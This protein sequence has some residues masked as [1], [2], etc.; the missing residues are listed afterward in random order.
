VKTKLILAL[1][2][3]C[4]IASAQ[5]TWTQKADFGGAARC[6]AVGF[7]IGTK[8]YIGTGYDGSTLYKDF[9][10]WDQATNVWTQKVDFGGIGRDEAI[11]FSIGTKGYIG[12]G[13]Y[14]N[15]SIWTSLKDFWEWNQTTNV[16]T[17][18][19]NFGG[20]ARSGA[21]GF[22]IGT[23]G[24]IGTGLDSTN[25]TQDFWEWNQAT[26][27]WTQKANFGGTI[28]YT[29]VGFSINTM[30]YIGTGLD[31][32]N[33]TQDFWQWNQ[34]TNVWTQKA[35]FSG[36]ARGEATGFCINSKGYIGTGTG[37]H[38][39]GD[40]WEWNQATN[41]WTQKANF[42][43]V[44]RYLAVGF[45]ISSKGYIGLGSDGNNFQDFWEFDPNGNGVNEISNKISVSVFPNPS[46]GMFTIQANSQQ[47]L[48]NN[49]IE[50]YNVL[51]ECIYQHICISANQQIDLSSQP[52][53]VY[54]YQISSNAK[55]LASGKFVKE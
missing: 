55:I 44:A 46:S 7:S 45:S 47:L 12:M 23:K 22:S 28:K 15:G 17:Q 38:P 34:A 30:G 41:V 10:E 19:A 1:L 13:S 29:S 31:S 36:T 54:L 16:W 42:G 21:I 33:A 14:F 37:M 24:Y 4:G 3:I 8:G 35:N 27:I 26:N 39:Y 11:G 9:W 40:F 48:A 49:Q 18:K 32:T 50:I 2:T 52:S 51:G 6:G 53:G 20:T 43:G 25:A 5:G